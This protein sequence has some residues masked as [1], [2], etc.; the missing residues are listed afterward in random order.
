[1]FRPLVFAVASVAVCLA[2]SPAFEVASIRPHVFLSDP[3]SESSDT[4]VLPGG[5]FVGSNVGI[6]KL[7]RNAFA[8]EDQRISGIPG[9]VDSV[10]YDINA[11]TAG[12]IEIDRTNIQAL[13]LQLL[14]D[15]FR[16]RYHRNAKEETVF[17]LETAKDGLRLRPHTGG[18]EP[19]MSTNS[20]S[21]T[22]T[23]RAT[24]LSLPDF[25]AS[26]ARQVGRPVVD[27]T[28]VQ[29]EFDFDLRWTPDQAPDAAGPSI[30]AALQPLG[31][32]LVSTRRQVEIVVI[33]QV[34][35]PSSN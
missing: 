5:R 35:K 11:R 12:G 10:S 34:E 4:K 15:R 6:R 33:D 23:L 16:L 20:G 18:G 27:A 21:G 8:I 24:R 26:L 32:R 22:V 30:F 17:T 14:E 7:I 29:G 3:N 1:M 13:M 28:G 31:L 2:Q 19:S 25:A 9:W